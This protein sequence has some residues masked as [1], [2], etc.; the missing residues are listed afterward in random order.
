MHKNIQKYTVIFF[1]LLL[2]N[3]CASALVGGAATIGLAGVQ[4]RSFKD[5]AIDL[6]VEMLIQDNFHILQHLQPHNP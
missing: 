6:E 4:E 2:L 1:I 3:G 5:A